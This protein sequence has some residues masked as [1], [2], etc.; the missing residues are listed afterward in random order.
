MVDVEDEVSVRLEPGARV[1][2][3][4]KVFEAYLDMTPFGRHR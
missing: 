3:D 2:V 1:R 4:G